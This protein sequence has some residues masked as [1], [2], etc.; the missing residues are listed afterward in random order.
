[1]NQ[2][3]AC[4][5]AV[6]L[7]AT[8]ALAQKNLIKQGSRRLIKTGA[9][10]KEEFIRVPGR[11]YHINTY[12]PFLGKE[13]EPVGQAILGNALHSAS[14]DAILYGYSRSARDSY[15]RSVI[16]LR[17]TNQWNTFTQNE[18]AIRAALKQQRFGRQPIKYDKM[19]D[20]SSRWIFLG[21]MHGHTPIVE[22]VTAFVADFA[23]R[24]PD[25]P[26]YLA[27]EFLDTRNANGENTFI[28]NSSQE[29]EKYADAVAADKYKYFQGLLDSGVNLVG[30]EDWAEFTRQ[31]NKAAKE[32]ELGRVLSKNPHYAFRMA[33]SLWG[34]EHR[35]RMWAKR[36]QRLRRRV[37]PQ[38]Y[39]FVY[40]GAGHV[41]RALLNNLPVLLKADASPVITFSVYD[42]NPVDFFLWDG[43]LRVTKKELP[44]VKCTPTGCEHPQK[45][46]MWH[47]KDKLKN[48]L[49]ADGRV[50][51]F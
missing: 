43:Y 1:M 6:L 27:T 47:K 12:Q 29:L 4:L 30:L 10:L 22:E 2:P 42:A 28:I 40:A 26:V 35:N 13:S 31:A 41:N 37:G 45:L 16:P 3:L 18:A 9:P 48:L 25:V 46:F 39:I 8:P 23:R 19:F 34:V 11:V 33:K 15:V 36:L 49:G 24:H 38:A 14:L 5:L 32:A 7:A 44:F 17:W 21:E 50:W 20:F 51:F